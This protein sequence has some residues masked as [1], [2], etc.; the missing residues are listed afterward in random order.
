MQ[1]NPPPEDVKA[2]ELVS[3]P[4]IAKILQDPEVKEFIELLKSQP[5]AAQQ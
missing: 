5:D 1:K 2:R 3:D 4:K